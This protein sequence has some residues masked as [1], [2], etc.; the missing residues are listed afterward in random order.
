MIKIF[1]P[2]EKIH[3]VDDYHCFGCSPNNPSGLKLSFMLEDEV[4]YSEITPLKIHEG[5]HNIL[6][7]GIAATLHDEIAAWYVYTVL[8]TSGVTSSMDIKYKK[9]VYT[10][11]GPLRL[12][13]SLKETNRRLAKIYT[14]LYT[15]DGTLASEAEVTYFIF[16]EDVAK[17][18]YMYP[19]KDAF[20]S[21]STT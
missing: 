21:S 2:F 1:N 18:D 12:N 9:P 7:G 8:G 14:R 20:Y 3:K 6:H 13:A 11:K 19:G 5:Y 17:R 16:P 10:N 4:L 15:G